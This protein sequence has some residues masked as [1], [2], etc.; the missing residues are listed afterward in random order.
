MARTCK[1]CMR[2]NT[3]T[4]VLYLGLLQKP[5]SSHLIPLLSLSLE[6]GTLEI[7]TDCHKQWMA[8]MKT[9]FENPTLLRLAPNSEQEEPNGP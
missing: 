4:L 3:A 1:R 2:P 9:W 7:C 6:G 8:A 5:V